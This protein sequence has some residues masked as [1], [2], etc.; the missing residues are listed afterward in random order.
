MGSPYTLYIGGRG[1]GKLSI[2]GKINNIYASNLTGD[3]KSLITIE[4]PITDCLFMNGIYTGTAPSAITYKIDK[5]E[6]KNII[7]VNLI[8]TSKD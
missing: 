6:T 4:A 7:E 8:K 1:Y 3:G 2:A 5:S